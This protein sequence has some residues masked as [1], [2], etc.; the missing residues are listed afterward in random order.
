[1]SPAS[2]YKYTNGQKGC[3][4]QVHVVYQQTTPSIAIEEC[5]AI[6]RCERCSVV[7]PCSSLG[8]SP[9]FVL[10]LPHS[11]A[12]LRMFGNSCAWLGVGIGPLMAWN[13]RE[14]LSYQWSTVQIQTCGRSICA[15]SAVTC[16]MCNVIHCILF[17]FLP[18][19]WLQ[20]L[21]KTCS[22]SIQSRPMVSKF[23]LS[24]QFSMNASTCTVDDQCIWHLRM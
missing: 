4:I 14:D 3:I 17:F 12:S 23:G 24:L 21:Q 8:L 16:S 13:S 7:L 2:C 10:S 18:F 22:S 20:D 11:F 6:L 1:M 15:E 5:N 9:C 19:N